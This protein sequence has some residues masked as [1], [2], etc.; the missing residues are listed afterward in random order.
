M[1]VKLQVMGIL[2]SNESSGFYTI[3]ASTYVDG[4]GDVTHNGDWDK[5][6]ECWNSNI[7]IYVV[8]GNR[9]NANGQIPSRGFVTAF[10]ADDETGE[11]T[12]FKASEAHLGGLP[13][14]NTVYMYPDGTASLYVN[15]LT[16]YNPGT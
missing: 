2:D 12:C 11:F 6:V 5:M 8:F 14:I 3:L 7:P 9:A 10:E 13:E 1:P 16:A 4:T 15:P